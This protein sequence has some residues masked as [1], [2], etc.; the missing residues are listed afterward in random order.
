M[1]REPGPYPWVALGYKNRAEY[2]AAMQAAGQHHYP[3]ESARRRQLEGKGYGHGKKGKQRREV[4]EFL[5]RLK[6][7]GPVII[8]LRNL[9]IKGW[10]YKQGQGWL[11]SEAA[12]HSEVPIVIV[13]HEAYEQLQSAQSMEEVIVELLDSAFEEDFTPEDIL[14]FDEDIEIR[15]I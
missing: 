14:E 2:R 6:G 11:T 10:Q 13:G 1:K 5:E 7:R 8:V 9:V 15:D 4:K 3:L 12:T